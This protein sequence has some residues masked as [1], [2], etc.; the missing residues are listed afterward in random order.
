MKIAALIL[1]LLAFQTKVSAGDG[2]NPSPETMSHPVTI[3]HISTASRRDF[4]TTIQEFEK[5]LG[6][7]DPE[8][9]K[10]LEAPNPDV[11]E[12]RSK[13]EAMAGSSGFMRFGNVQTMGHLLPFVGR[14]TGHANQY[15][16]GNPLIAVQ[17]TQYHPGAGLYAPLRILIYEDAS[18]VTHFEYD[19]PS[20][21]FGQ[22]GDERIT[23][24]GLMLDQKMADLVRVAAGH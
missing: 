23:K 17:M 3:Q 8:A 4:A 1:A 10:A 2:A 22:F 21:L 11:E 13:I 18:A 15:L 5:Q 16:V 7:F 19:L 6:T 9:L 20:S 12:I 24:V 14:P